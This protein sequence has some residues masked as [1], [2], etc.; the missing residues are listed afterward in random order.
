LNTQYETVNDSEVVEIDEDDDAQ[1]MKEDEDGVAPVGSM[2]KLTSIVWN[3]FSIYLNK[4]VLFMISL[5]DNFGSIIYIFKY[6]LCILITV[7]IDF[8][9]YI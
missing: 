4:F 1:I 9:R 7:V 6:S 5:P 2:R 8:L 3:E